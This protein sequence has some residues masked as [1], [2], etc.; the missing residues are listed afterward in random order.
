M[1]YRTG[2]LKLDLSQV[3]DI[4][5]ERTGD[6]G[7][8]LCLKLVLDDVQKP[9]AYY[10]L[11]G[12]YRSKDVTPYTRKEFKI[13]FDEFTEFSIHL[14]D[15]VNKGEPVK[16]YFESETGKNVEGKKIYMN[17]GRIINPTAEDYE[18]PGQPFEELFHTHSPTLYDQTDNTQP[19]TED[20]FDDPQYWID[21]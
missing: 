4:Y 3:V 16:L 13:K 8:F 2:R 7:E 21:L 15:A 11:K 1:G 5:L 20:G 10:G 12:N 17:P 9:S 18:D 6:E 14:A 19:M